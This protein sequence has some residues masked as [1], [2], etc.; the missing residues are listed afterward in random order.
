MFRPDRTYLKPFVCAAEWRD[1]RGSN[2][3]PCNL[4]TRNG[5][6]STTKPRKLS[7]IAK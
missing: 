1:M 4:Q 2:A 6:V 7:N 5:G 3:E